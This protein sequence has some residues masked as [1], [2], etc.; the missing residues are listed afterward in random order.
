MRSLRQIKKSIS[1]ARVELK[2]EA[3]QVV[4]RHLL[5]ELAGAAG[6]TPP[7]HESETPSAAD[8]LTVGCLN[9]AFR[10]GGLEAVERLCDVAAQRLGI[11]PRRVTVEELIQECSA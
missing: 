1:H 2:A 3:D 8:L 6:G 10:R 9:A 5:A 4:L 11:C 7:L